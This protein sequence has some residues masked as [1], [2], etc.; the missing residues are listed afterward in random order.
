MMFSSAANG[1]PSGGPD[2]DA[3][4]GEPLAEVVVGVAVEAQGHAP[5]HEGAEALSGRAG[6]GQV[7]GPVG[8][9]GAAVAAGDLVAEQGAD[10][11]V[12]VA[13]A[14]LRAHRR[15]VL[16]GRPALLEERVVER[17][18]ET[19]VLLGSG[20]PPRRAGRVCGSTRI[21][22]RS[23]PVG[24]PV[25]D[26][27]GGVE[28]VD[29]SHR[30]VERAEAERG[31]VLADLLG[32]VLE[33][34]LDELR[35]AAEALPQLGVLGGDPDRAGVEVAD[36]HHDAARHHQRVR[37]RSRTPRRR[38]A[39]RSPRRGRSSSARRPGRRCGPAGRWRP[40]SA[41]SR[42]APAPRGCPAC[43]SEVSGAAPVPP[44]WPE[45]STTSE[46]ALATPAATVPTPDL[47]HQ[48]H[49]HPGPRIGRLQ[50]VDEL[51]DV[52]DRVDVVVRRR[53]DQ[54]DARRR[55]PGA[56]RSRD[57]PCAPGSWPP[58][59]GLAPWAILIWRSS[60]LT[61]YSQVT[62]NRPE[63]TCLMA[64]RRRSPFGVGRVAVGV[65]AALAG[66]RP[67]AEA[68]HGDGQRLVRLGRDRAVG[69]RAGREPGHDRGDRLD[70]VDRDR[71]QHPGACSRIRPR[72]VA[73]GAAWS[74]TAA[75]YSLKIS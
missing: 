16:D 23:R 55:V 51:G 1:E 13:D 48:L 56:W 30:L 2:D 40:G 47:G 69:H 64:L 24:L 3:A 10:G 53:R 7:D 58:S 4:A 44:S 45:M 50:V 59:P 65:L 12:D 39:R 60:A 36:A 9:A 63:A 14:Q 37:W 46:W 42:P 52:L 41:G 70:L 72:R 74:S 49:V 32:D 54:P 20:A 21:G 71:R 66:V 25:A 75:V 18:V 11:A 43:L 61:R 5:G 8:Q 15:A 26:R 29:P 28:Q 19:V 68:V 31:Q 73:S 27:V 35:L 17:L 38:A 62:P 67:P 33:E 57:R 34:G 6:E 22:E